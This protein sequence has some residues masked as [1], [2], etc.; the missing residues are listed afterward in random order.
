M[1]DARH[2][3]FRSLA[4][5][6]FVLILI[7]GT[8]MALFSTGIQALIIFRQENFTIDNQLK[9][10]ESKLVPSINESLLRPEVQEVK[11]HLLT[12]LE[13]DFIED[14][15]LEPFSAKGKIITDPLNINKKSKINPSK[16]RKHF[17]VKKAYPLFLTL[18]AKKNRAGTLFIVLSKKNAYKKTI[19]HGGFIFII[20]ELQV[21]TLAALIFYLTR[22]LVTQPMKKISFDVR[23]LSLNKLETPIGISQHK[24]WLPNNEF[25]NINSALNH[26]QVNLLSDIQRLR[27]AELDLLSEK[28]EKLATRRQ[29]AA[30]EAANRAK[31]QFLATMSH[32]IR[33]PMNGVIGMVDL[34]QE[35]SLDKT[36]Q[37]YVDIIQRSSHALLEIINDILD[38]SKIEA[39]KLELE[40]LVFTLEDVMSDCISLF[41]G[42]AKQKNLQLFGFLSIRL[43]N[44]R[45]GDP[46]RLR[47]IITNLLSNAFKFTTSG[48]ISLY[49]EEVKSL[50]NLVSFH[51]YDSGIGIEN[52]QQHRLFG[53]Y[54]QANEST[55]RKFGG[56]GLGLSICKRLVE[57][58]GGEIGIESQLGKGSHF[59]FKIQLPISPSAQILTSSDT[60][61]NLFPQLINHLPDI[62]LKS[63]IVFT[64][65]ANT[66]KFMERLF[67]DLS[68]NQ[69]IH[70]E[71]CSSSEQFNQLKSRSL[72]TYDLWVFDDN[73]FTHNSSLYSTME[74]VL[75]QLIKKTNRHDNLGLHSKP[76]MLIGDKK[77]FQQSMKLSINETEISTITKPLTSTEFI[78]ALQLLEVDRQASPPE[79][80]DTEHAKPNQLEATQRFNHLQILAAEDNAVNRLVL[81]GLLNQMGINPHLVSDGSQ[82]VA[83]VRKASDPF[84]M[85]LMDCEM[86]IMNGLEATQAIRQY[87]QQESQIPT[88]IIAL[89][90]HSSCEYLETAT[91]AGMN[92]CLTKPVN[93]KTLEQTLLDWVPSLKA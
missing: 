16:T 87:Q 2:L 78:K 93:R 53:S 27:Q 88:P 61:N 91:K 4:S 81:K 42:Q 39:G 5:Q 54:L 34:L 66:K 15:Y 68:Y 23:Q 44:Q 71:Y 69:K 41:S 3:P 10:I 60:Q 14:V 48:Y 45:T 36:Q 17:Q 18:S 82:A 21:L 28:Q 11:D 89:T 49:I 84:D 25:N 29:K 26:M 70:S 7:A 73:I 13:I 46:T 57:M 77:Q 62:S 8:A 76:L 67:Q 38:H 12:L 35:T 65:D 30:A 47:Q 24:Q 72:S 22:K 9:Y 56:T 52:S 33:T 80:K 75:T 43:H 19:K 79:K 40:N 86:P 58:M 50:P 90:S 59:W 31:S 83:A 64:K 74:T 6:L 63:I 37:H 85:I 51:V 55:S 32:E 1:R 20:Q 92:H